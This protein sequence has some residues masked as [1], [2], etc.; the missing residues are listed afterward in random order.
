[1]SVRAWRAALLPCLASLLAACALAPA[2]PAMVS[3]LIDQRPADVPQRARGPA[4]LLVQRP[5]A[6]PAYDS[7]QMAYRLRPHHLAYYREHQWAETPPQMLAPLLVRTLDATGAFAAVVTPPYAGA[8][9]YTLDTELLELLQD[10]SVD[11]PVLRLALR[12]RL[13][14]AAARPLA[15]REFSVV[16]AMREKSP[17]GGVDAANAATAKAL[18]EIAGFVLQ[19]AR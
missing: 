16:E 1:M 17:Q 6:R 15:T 5:D 8:S 7:T 3:A 14:D 19:V 9:G 13:G 12:V 4:T 10:Y 2:E 18:R 11:P